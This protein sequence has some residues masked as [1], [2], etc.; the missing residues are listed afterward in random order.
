MLAY[1]R[2]LAV[3]DERFRSLRDQDSG[4]LDERLRAKRGR[5]EVGGKR[6]P[7]IVFENRS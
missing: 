4:G 7:R 2:D 3:L 5:I 1:S 6:A